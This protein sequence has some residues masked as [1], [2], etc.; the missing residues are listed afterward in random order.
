VTTV[1]KMVGPHRR[2]THVLF[3]FDGPVC[4]LFSGHPA[5]TVAARIAKE[6]RARQLM[7]PG[8]DDC[9]DPHRLLAEVSQEA[10]SMVSE[11]LER[12]ECLATESADPTDGAAQT[13][14]RL[15]EGGIRLSVVSNNS[16]TAVASYL[17]R[18]EL[19][20]YFDGPV[21]GRP[22][23]PGLMKPHPH[24]VEKALME[25]GVDSSRCLM[26]GDSVADAQAA[27]KAGVS[28]VGYEARPGGASEL[29][30]AGVASVLTSIEELLALV[31]L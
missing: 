16:A 1:E 5:A 10:R 9:T 20:R 3:D 17:T 25:L 15:A 8:L 11:L 19:D 24:S 27:G 30:N 23:D 7:P 31:G 12:A 22:D 13:V 14:R 4:R 21:V 18:H 6:L 28:F 29:R 26:V 2:P